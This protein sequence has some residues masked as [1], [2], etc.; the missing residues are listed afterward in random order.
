MN[1]VLKEI[2]SIVQVRG[3]PEARIKALE[4]LKKD[5]N[6]NL[7]NSVE[8]INNLS[9]LSYKNAGDELKKIA[10]STENI[11]QKRKT[12]YNQ[13]ADEYKNYSPQEHTAIKDKAKGIEHEINK[14]K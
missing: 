6:L 12:L 11:L 3:Y 1:S 8:F 7:A 5:E 4:I 14:T 9:V 13:A 10:D 2:R